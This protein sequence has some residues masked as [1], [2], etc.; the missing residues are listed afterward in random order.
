MKHVVLVGL[1]G[2]GKSTVGRALAERLARPFVDTDH[3]IEQRAG[4]PIP[5]LFAER[6]EPAFRALERA[7]VTEAVAGPPSVIATGGGAPLDP[8]NRH[9]LWAGN[10]V[11]WLDAPVEALVRRVGAAG[12]GRPLLAGGA[13]E[14]LATLRIEREPVYSL[15]HLHVE[16]EHTG[17][18]GAV[19]A[20]AARIEKVPA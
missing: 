11:I 19:D 2:S 3:L 17:V 8:D 20:I 13:L 6:G 16:T 18:D 12:D 14:R 10:L 15:A 4:V 5:R 9:H 7:A 1:S